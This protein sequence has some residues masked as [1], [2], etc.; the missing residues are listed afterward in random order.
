MCIIIYLIFSSK[1][2][3]KLKFIL[4]MSLPLMENLSLAVR[5][6]NHKNQYSENET[7]LLMST[8]FWYL[9]NC[10]RPVPSL[11]KKRQQELKN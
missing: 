10:L 4:K 8:R 9:W 11:F 3:F 1:L 6:Q 5:K 2:T 7:M